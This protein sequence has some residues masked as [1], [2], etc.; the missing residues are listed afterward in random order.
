MTSRDTAAFGAHPAALLLP[1]FVNGT[2]S[3]EDRGYVAEHV[4]SCAQCQREL[5]E[6]MRLGEQLRE[7]HASERPP[8][9]AVWR[10]VQ[11]GIARE[12]GKSA[13]WLGALDDA[14]RAL[15]APRL[16]P[17]LALALVIGQ[18]GVLAWM[19]GHPLRQLSEEVTTRSVAPPAAR[20]RIT[21]Q[22]DSSA[23]DTASLL[24]ELGARVVDGP[25]AEGFY[26]VEVPLDGARTV[27][28]SVELLRRRPH[29]IRS[30]ETLPAQ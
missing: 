1:A 8:S 6:C 13:R 15:L 9:A 14:L 29:V 5:D 22:P 28:G 11:E 27:A 16:A 20:L 12:R 10:K 23:R 30:V 18:F 19:L 21:L 2:L 25:S 24:R 7:F 4:E 3:G 26:I 17:T